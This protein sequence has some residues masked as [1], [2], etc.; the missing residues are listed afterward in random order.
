MRFLPTGWRVVVLEVRRCRRG[1]SSTWESE[2]LSQG[3]TRAGRKR[4]FRG[5]GCWD[6]YLTGAAWWARGF[7]RCWAGK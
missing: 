2:E 6:G 4:G 3:R 7:C 5:D 1:I